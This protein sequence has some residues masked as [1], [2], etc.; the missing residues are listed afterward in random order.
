VV[1]RSCERGDRLGHVLGRKKEDVM[2]ELVRRAA[3]DGRLRGV[4]AHGPSGWE[5]VG[6]VVCDRDY[7]LVS[8]AGAIIAPSAALLRQA[9]REEWG[10]TK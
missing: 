9:M 3:L 6:H 10:L 7:E 2:D 8:R 4:M 1:L 5:I